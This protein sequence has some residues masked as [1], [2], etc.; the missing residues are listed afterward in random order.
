MV[1]RVGAG[2]RSS[3]ITSQE[4]PHFLR[5]EPAFL[6]PAKARGSRIEGRIVFK[7]E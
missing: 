6:L 7:E 5:R 3:Y 1:G 4:W 2:G